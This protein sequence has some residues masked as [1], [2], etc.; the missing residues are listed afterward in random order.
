MLKTELAEKVSGVKGVVD[1]YGEH[2]TKGNITISRYEFKNENDFLYNMRLAREGNLWMKMYDGH[3]VR[4]HVG[5]E[6]M[7]SDTVME[8]NSN[9][10]FIDKAHGKVL[11]GGLGIGMVLRNILDKKEVESVVVIELSQDLIDLVG[12]RFV[13]PKLTIIN[14]DIF[15]WVPEKGTKYDSLYFDI[16]PDISTENLPEIAKLHNKF[17][18]YR[19]RDN[20]KSFMESWMQDYLRKE[21]RRENNSRWGW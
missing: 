5:R 12:P 14:G 8:R 21:K 18:N 13:H 17:K 10:D 7:M 19:N 2:E 6:L 3:Y 1:L 16:W 15:S 4:M 11:I 9:R 20:P